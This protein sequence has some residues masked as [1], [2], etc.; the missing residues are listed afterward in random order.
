METVGQ[1]PSGHLPWMSRY[2]N[3]TVDKCPWYFI[4][5]NNTRV[6]LCI[7]TQYA[8]SGE[9]RHGENE[10]LPMIYLDCGCVSGID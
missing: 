8:R 9:Y 3:L 2:T 4:V 6:A 7:L 1:V 10:I 5:D